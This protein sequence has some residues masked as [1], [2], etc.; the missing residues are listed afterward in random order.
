MMS[1]VISEAVPEA[2][3]NL[4]DANFADHVLLLK[5]HR[6][7][8]KASTGKIMVICLCH[9]YGQIKEENRNTRF[10]RCYALTTLNPFFGL[11]ML[12]VEGSEDV[13]R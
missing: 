10:V 9:L 3:G 8:W 12:C 11:K 4:K 2:L 13:W 6:W 5:H 7:S 1:T